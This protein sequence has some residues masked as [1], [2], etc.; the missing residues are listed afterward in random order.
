MQIERC[1]SFQHV[2]D[3]VIGLVHHTSLGYR[4]HSVRPDSITVSVD[5][6][7][8]VCFTSEARWAE[9]DMSDIIRWID[10]GF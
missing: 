8:L 2:L 7:S 9:Q 4:I 6:E 3:R 5:L 10:N 1:S